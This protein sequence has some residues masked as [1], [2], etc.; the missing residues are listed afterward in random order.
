MIEI[1][2]LIFIITAVL[3]CALAAVPEL[4]EAAAAIRGGR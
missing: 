3:G 2:S 1:G 4:M